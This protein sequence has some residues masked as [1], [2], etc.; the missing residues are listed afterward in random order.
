MLASPPTV[1][2]ALGAGQKVWFVCPDVA[3]LL[4]VDVFQMGV[5]V[6]FS[7][8]IKIPPIRDLQHT[9]SRLVRLKVELQPRAPGP[10]P[11]LPKLARCRD[12]LIEQI[13]LEAGDRVQRRTAQQS[14]GGVR[15]QPITAWASPARNDLASVPL[16]KVVTD[17]RQAINAAV[18]VVPPSAP[19]INTSS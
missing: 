12:L 10:L 6:Q 5:G 9:Q 1:F 18:Q 14:A 2:Q 7:I 19:K 17:C 3:D 13:D 8:P 4:Q 16:F 11:L 15:D